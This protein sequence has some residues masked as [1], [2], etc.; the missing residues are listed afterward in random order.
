[1]EEDEES[2]NDH[3]DNDD[4]D[5]DDDNQ[6]SD[7]ESESD[8]EIDEEQAVVWDNPYLTP[9][10]TV[11]AVLEYLSNPKSISGEDLQKAMD[12]VVLRHGNS[13]NN[14]QKRAGNRNNN[15]NATHGFPL[16]SLLSCDKALL[17]WENHAEWNE[18]AATDRSSVPFHRVVVI[19]G[20]FRGGSLDVR[21]VAF[22]VPPLSPNPPIEDVPNA[23]RDAIRG[24]VLGR[25]RTQTKR[26][27]TKQN[28]TM[29]G[30][31]DKHKRNRTRTMSC[32][33]RSFLP[34]PLA[35]H[36]HDT[37]RVRIIPLQPTTAPATTRG[38]VGEHAC[39]QPCWWR[40]RTDRSRTK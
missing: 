20:H 18:G 10:V 15:N 21:C 33:F 19:G 3:D 22:F 11:P 32:C 2:E 35:C 38:F 4:D 37:T 36:A 40:I 24:T 34:I 13:N 27:L 23:Y 6:E 17:H 31:G 14:K 12:D 9:T 1:V 8:E 25:E 16:R 29:D 30:V 5:D 28:K 7:S 26:T 39:I